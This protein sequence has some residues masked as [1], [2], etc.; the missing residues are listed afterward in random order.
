MAKAWE[1][2]EPEVDNK[3]GQYTCS[4]CGEPLTVVRWYRHPKYEEKKEM[5]GWCGNQKCELHL[6]K[7][8]AKTAKQHE[9][10]REQIRPDR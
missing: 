4:S 2:L 5:R 10:E 8:L 3:D 7:Q 6:Q 1:A 9:H